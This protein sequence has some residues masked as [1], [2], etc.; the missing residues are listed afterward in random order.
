[1][2]AKLSKSAAIAKIKQSSGTSLHNST[3][4]FANLNSSKSVWWFDIPAEKFTAGKH[5]ALDIL[6]F[7]DET[8]ELHHLR[9]PTA[10]V[11]ENR[12]RFHVREDKN[13]LSLELSSELNN[14]FQDV[15]PTSGRMP[16]AQFLLGTIS[17]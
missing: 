8:N 7:S 9:V 13:S 6:V 11:R 5:N 3:T 12:E 17:L 14:R 1:M 10:Y 2:T 15:R 16:F 4:H